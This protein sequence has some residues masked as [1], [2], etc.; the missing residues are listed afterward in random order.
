MSSTACRV[1]LIQLA[2]TVVVAAGTLMYLNVIAAMS[3][4]GSTP[5]S[6]EVQYGVQHIR[7]VRTGYKTEERDVT[8]KVPEISVPFI[9]VTPESPL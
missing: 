6:V 1:I 8:M 7:V 4:A 5:M 3:A 2:V 9:V